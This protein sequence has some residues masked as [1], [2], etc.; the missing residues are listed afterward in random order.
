MDMPGDGI[1]L[2]KAF[3]KVDLQWPRLFWRESKD[4]KFTKLAAYRRDWSFEHLLIFPVAVG[5][6]VP[7]VLII[8]MLLVLDVFLFSL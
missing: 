5:I 1:A 2:A 3:N 4:Q 7:A 6:L 8:P